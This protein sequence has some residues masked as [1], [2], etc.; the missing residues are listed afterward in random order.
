MVI[1][2]EGV[3]YN[4]AS[5]TNG[6][7]YCCARCGVRDPDGIYLETRMLSGFELGTMLNRARGLKPGRH[8]NIHYHCL[9]TRERYIWELHD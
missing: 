6:G 5:S 1:E 3:K 7:G 2:H 9:T 4:F 8:I